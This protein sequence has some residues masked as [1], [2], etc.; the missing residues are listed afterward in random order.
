MIP[1]ICFL[2]ALGLFFRSYDAIAT[3]PLT[4][5]DCISLAVKNNLSLIQAKTAIERAEAEV[6]DS[7]SSYYPEFDLSSSYR[8]G[9]S[10]LEEGR[11]STNLEGRITLYRGGYIRAGTRA[12]KATRRA[13]EEGY[14]ITENEIVLAVKEA[15][16]KILQKQDQMTLIDNI[17]QR[18][19]Q[20]RIIIKLKYDAGRESSPAVK[21]A[22]ANVLQA[23][24]EMMSAE[25]ELSLAKGSL[26]LILGRPWKEELSVFYIES[27]AEL[28]SL[29]KMIEG[30][31]ADRPDIRAETARRAVLEAQTTQAKSAYLPTVA[32][33]SSYG[34]QGKELLKQEDNWS[35]GV[36]LSFP[37]FDGFSTKAKVKEA[38]LSVREQDTKIEKLKQDIEEEVEQAWINWQLAEKNHE[39]RNT[40]LEA[41][42][43]MYQ[44]TR[45]QYE[46][47][48]TSYL[49][50]QQ[51]ESALTQAEYSY[52]NSL[53]DL[54]IARARL[55]KAW[56]RTVS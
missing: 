29:E 27:D 32:M 16:F 7:Y 36:S 51:K 22:E 38:T 23:E 6:L 26:N 2:L 49:F 34:L 37:L 18:R 52:L 43:E 42:R 8:Y 48:Q 55:Q 39:V 13:E 45:L 41:A 46:Q 21:E 44:L 56:G 24:Y 33:S 35:V 20:D 15:F 9:E 30:A 11:Y 19:E 25:G 4:L 53:Y 28:P 47:G 50:L 40:S 14:F 10:P 17:L 5:E 54:R 31:Q 12:A 3:E 1:R